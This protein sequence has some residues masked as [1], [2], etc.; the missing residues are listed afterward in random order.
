M[1][2]HINKKKKQK[3]L[4]GG[5]EEQDFGTF[6]IYLTDLFMQQNTESQKDEPFGLKVEKVILKMLEDEKNVR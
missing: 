5:I 6:I 4:L 3:N 1:I 2:S